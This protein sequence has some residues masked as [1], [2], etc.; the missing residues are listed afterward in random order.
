[1]C[2]TQWDSD[3]H[4]LLCGFGFVPEPLDANGPLTNIAYAR[5]R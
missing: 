3:A 4:R 2:E 1:V 5:P